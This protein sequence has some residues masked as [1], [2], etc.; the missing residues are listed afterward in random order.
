MG[1][2]PNI[3][4]LQ[5]RLDGTLWVRYERS[6]WVYYERTMDGSF[7]KETEILAVDEDEVLDP[8]QSR[9]ISW[10]ED[11]KTLMSGFTEQAIPH[12]IYE[13]TK[14]RSLVQICPAAPTMST[15]SSGVITYR[16]DE[17]TWPTE[18]GELRYRVEL[19]R[20]GPMLIERHEQTG[21]GLLYCPYKQA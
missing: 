5:A 21:Q 11:R 9:S 6:G 3:H 14:G 16:D 1:R 15:N 2:G 7:G 19:R 10:S 18:V 8:G 4:L 12:R 17:V 13:W 20:T